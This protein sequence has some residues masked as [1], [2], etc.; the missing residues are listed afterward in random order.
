VSGRERHLVSIRRTIVDEGVHYDGAWERLRVAATAAGANAWRFTS[1]SDETLRL[2]F[3]EFRSS[4]DPRD[5]AE[6]TEALSTL[7]NMAPG[8]REEWV[9]VQSTT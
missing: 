1:A 8:T 4:A 6:V 2:E 7:D 5:R 3:L 9:E